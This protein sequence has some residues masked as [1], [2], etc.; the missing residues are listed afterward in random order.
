MEGRS[1]H[2]GCSGLASCHMLGP[3]EH[4]GTK[5][6]EEVCVVGVGEGEGARAVDV[7]EREKE[8]ERI[9]KGKYLTGGTRK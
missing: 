1:G 6:G 7:C 4:S 9:T 3:C 2:P 5:R 8:T